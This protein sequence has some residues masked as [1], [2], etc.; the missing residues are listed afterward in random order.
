M[1]I[2]IRDVF[3]IAL[4][5]IGISFIIRGVIAAAPAVLAYTL[6]RSQ[7][8]G[9]NLHLYLFLLGFEA[10]VLLALGLFSFIRSD[11]IAERTLAE[12]KFPSLIEL[13]QMSSQ[14]IFSLSL[15]TAGLLLFLEAIPQILKK[16]PIFAIPSQL[17]MIS[18]FFHPDPIGLLSQAVSVLIAIWL[19]ANPQP[20]V[21]LILREKK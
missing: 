15:R 17:A 8:E 10:A 20:L 14:V 13:N 3:S 11:R 5:L 2:T 19:I 12:E 16:M 21:N 4:K 7:G 1:P 9:F 18:I 6:E